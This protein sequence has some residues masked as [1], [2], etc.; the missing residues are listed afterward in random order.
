MP[1]RFDRGGGGTPLLPRAASV[2][3]QVG[4]DQSGADQDLRRG[5]LG[6]LAVAGIG[7]VEPVRADHLG[8]REQAARHPGLH[9]RVTTDDRDAE[10][11][12][13]LVESVAIGLRTVHAAE[14]A[15]PLLVHQQWCRRLSGVE[16]AIRYV[17]ALHAVAAELGVPVIRRSDLMHEWVSRGVLTQAEMIGPDGLHM[18][19]AGYGQLARAVAAQ[20]LAGAGIKN[21]ALTRD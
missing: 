19:D 16:G 15:A 17:E 3:R 2:L 6:E 14:A 18:T 4:L 10:F 8:R 13:D 11:G 5:R 1:G 12:R 7:H 21:A 20:L 9:H